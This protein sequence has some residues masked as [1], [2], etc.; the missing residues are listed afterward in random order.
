MPGLVLD[1]SVIAAWL[2]PGERSDAI[3]EILTRVVEEGAFVPD[4]WR[5][6]VLN[7]LLVA[8]RRGRIAASDRARALAITGQL[9][10]E[11]DSETT[12]R[13]WSDIASIAERHRLTAYDAAY[14]ELAHRTGLPLATLDQDLRAAAMQLGVALAAE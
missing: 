2:L 14:L 5:I 8:E 1:C 3:D 6:E 4:I 10:I 11:I 13:A 9:P 12:D 7:T